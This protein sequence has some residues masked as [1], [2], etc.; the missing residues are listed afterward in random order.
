MFTKFVD[1]D[2]FKDNNMRSNT[3]PKKL[4]VLKSLL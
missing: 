1:E 2:I 4:G 3:E